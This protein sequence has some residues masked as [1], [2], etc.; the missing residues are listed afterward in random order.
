M[1]PI[2]G[3]NPQPDLKAIRANAELFDELVDDA[4]ILA[5]L[6]YTEALIAALRETPIGNGHQGMCSVWRGAG[7]CDCI[8]KTW[9]ER[10]DALLPPE[11][12]IAPASAEP[13]S[14]IE[15]PADGTWSPEVSG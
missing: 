5:L 3:S 12:Q 7:Y 6:D 4:E 2:L 13:R 11:P 9:A 8:L 15:H 14:G 1:S 10:R